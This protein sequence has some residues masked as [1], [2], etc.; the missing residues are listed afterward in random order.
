MPA[1][2][3]V[4]L[5]RRLWEATEALLRLS[6]EATDG[7]GD[8]V[9]VGEPGPLQL[10]CVRRWRRRRANPFDRRVEVPEGLARHGRRDLGADAEWNDRFVSDEEPARLVHRVE[11]RRHVERCHRPQVDHLD[12]DAVVGHLLCCG[13]RLVDHA[14]DRHDGH[15][16]SGT[17]DS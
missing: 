3:D 11:D 15:V 6:G 9:A 5:Q 13:D 10:W 4:A 8:V 17:H 2:R 12:R 1:V 7:V 14:G 16:G